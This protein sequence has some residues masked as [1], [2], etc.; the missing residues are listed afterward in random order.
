MISPL[1]ISVENASKKFKLKQETSLKDSF[2][3]FFNPKSRPSDDF[4]ALNNVSVD[5]HAGETIG[6]IGHN[7]SG[8]STLLKLIGGI[9]DPTSGSVKSRGKLAALLELGAGFHPDLSGKDNVFLNAA[10]LG[11]SREETEARYDE[12]VN[13]AGI[14]DFMNTQVKFYSSGMF[15][16][17]AFS[18]AVHTDPDILIIDEVLAVG[19]EAFQWRCFE[20]INEFKNKGCTIVL[21]SHA[22]DQ[23]Q[24]LCDR[25][26]VLDH[27]HVVFD[28]LP[29]ESVKVFRELQLVDL[30]SST[31]TNALSSNSF[32]FAR[33]EFN[34]QVENGKTLQGSEFSISFQ[35]ISKE[36]VPEVNFALIFETISGQD[37]CG[38]TSHGKN[39]NL[40]LR[41]GANQFEIHFPE[42]IQIGG[43]HYYIAIL[44]LDE[45]GSMLHSAK[46][47][48]A[49]DFKQVNF[50][51]GFVASEAN[52][53]QS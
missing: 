43:G 25:V 23:V 49:V 36:P 12:I 51:W 18:V 27:G 3:N 9:I 46:H 42:G 37:I 1:V 7:G 34:S 11:M 20:K 41:S 4:W 24:Q 50:N 19:D 45:S 48:L 53:I 39:N 14:P 26:L 31:L 22:L 47:L 40:S 52:F 8:K 10:L 32:S 2:L 13:F 44:L 38:F 33:V 30:N 6:L 35:M 17:L 5:I 16:R 15:V 28:G 21:V 29:S